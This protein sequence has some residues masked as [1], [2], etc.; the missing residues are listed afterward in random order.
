MRKSKK[1]KKKKKTFSTY[2]IHK[3][4]R[5]GQPRYQEYSR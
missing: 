3:Q 1:Q 5:T 4:T 2:I